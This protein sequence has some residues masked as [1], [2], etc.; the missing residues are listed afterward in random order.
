MASGESDVETCQ[1]PMNQ[2][3][4]LIFFISPFP[5]GTIPAPLSEISNQIAEPSLFF[6]ILV[7][8]TTVNYW[9]VICYGNYK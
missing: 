7:E 2:H 3:L 4:S 9:S 8:I 1:K 6:C 5:L